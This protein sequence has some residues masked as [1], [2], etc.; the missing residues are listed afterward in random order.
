MRDEPLDILL[1]SDTLPIEALGQVKALIAACEGDV[2]ALERMLD[3]PGAKPKFPSLRGLTRYA[4]PVRVPAPLLRRIEAAARRVWPS[5]GSGK[6]AIEEGLMRAVAFNANPS[7]L[8]FL[9]DAIAFTQARDTLTSTRRRWA[10]AGV[11]FVAL[12]H[13]DGEASS[14]LDQ[15]LTH[16]DLR[17]RTWAVHAV[18]RTRRSRGARLTAKAIE[19]LERVGREDP[20]FEPRFV[21]R[22]RLKEAGREITAESAGG[23]YAFAATFGH[24]SRTVELRSEQTLDQLAWA[25]VDAFGWDSDH[26]YAFTLS[27]ELE[28]HAFE[29]AC[30][31]APGSGQDAGDGPLSMP[32]GALGMPAGHRFGMLYDF[33]DNNVF[34][35]RLVEVKEQAV[36]HASYPRVAARTGKAPRQY[37]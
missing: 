26:L 28:D 22:L 23:V 2:T 24:A 27:L 30:E 34:A 14:T 19:L 13:G 15:L 20:A 18:A 5:A 29:M 11:A 8:P 33:G 12:K 4:P 9:L 35:V 7:S 17:V 21:A 1:R 3:A 31:V 37:R 25:I 6:S 16:D 36:A 10:V 32:I